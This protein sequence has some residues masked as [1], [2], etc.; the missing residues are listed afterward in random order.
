MK[1][2]T[3]KS[4][5]TDYKVLMDSIKEAE[6]SFSMFEDLLKKG[7]NSDD[8]SLARSQFLFNAYSRKDIDNLDDDLLVEM[9][10]KIRK[11]I[12]PEK[13]V[14]DD[15]E[16]SE[17]V[18]SN[19]SKPTNSE[20]IRSLCY[21][22]Y[23]SSDGQFGELALEENLP[24][25]ESYEPEVLDEHFEKE[26][27]KIKSDLVRSI[28][29]RVKT[30]IDSYE[31]SK[32]NIE[33]LKS[34]AGGISQEYSKYMCS[35][36]FEEKKNSQIKELEERLS[37]E[38]KKENITEADMVANKKMKKKLDEMKAIQSS[39]FI[40]NRLRSLGEKEV[41]NIVK[42]Y[43][44]DKRSSYIIE[45]F[46]GKIERTG[47][48]KRIY[49]FFF[50]IEEKYLDDE[51]HVFN[52]LFLFI[53]MR[54]VAYSDV[55]NETGRSY[56]RSI[57]SSLAKLI[58]EK[59]NEEQKEKFLTIVK[60]TLDF[61]EDYRDKFDKDNILHPNHPRR[62]EHDKEKEK[63]TRDMIY[64]VLKT[65]KVEI[66]EEITSMSLSDLKDFYMK[67][68][69]ELEEDSVKDLKDFIDKTSPT[70]EEYVEDEG[71]KDKEKL[72]SEDSS[73]ENEVPEESEDTLEDIN[74]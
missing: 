2:N 4:A 54:F 38:M 17:E 61:F 58:Y 16:T 70:G 59:Y 26:Y 66:T 9:L 35:H 44:D 13:K 34:E 1:E 29:L 41:K 11:P 48:D 68:L 37:E 27:E 60:E 72:I 49:R 42:N 33:E 14:D 65:N 39:S 51:Y 69:E 52:N 43:F 12:L 30:D 36:E 25:G 5:S 57:V 19:N 40:L 62:I 31:E 24:E 56:V 23:T 64:S 22:V 6:D 46:I 63:E 45:K 73:N 53:V 55:E 10:E 15:V 74:K 21:D 7:L 3:K 32:K 18:T 47:F 28:L 20:W 67:K 50:N 8:I 71:I